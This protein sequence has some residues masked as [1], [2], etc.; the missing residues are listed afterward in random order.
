[1]VVLSA[2]LRILA[3]VAL[4]LAFAGASALLLQRRVLLDRLDERIG[5]D[6]A[7]EVDE[8]RRL[9]E[10]RNPETGEPFQG[11]AAAIL[12]TFLR[13]NIPA[14]G[15]VM[16]ALVEGQPPRATPAPYALWDDP[17]LVER[18]SALTTSEHGDLSTPGGD[19]RYLAV[20]LASDSQ[21]RGVFVVAFFL[22]EPREEIAAHLRV[23]SAIYGG[24]LLVALALA[25]LVAGRVL[26]P[27]RT[28]TE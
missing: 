2:R 22:D 7:Q 10:G 28:V 19:V 4:L 21:V 17:D 24:V 26:A 1:R 16:L 18:W 27:V 12:D 3:W 8:V 25:W 14:D 15:E 6:L 9:A 13:R 5:G 23:E 11:D 20:P